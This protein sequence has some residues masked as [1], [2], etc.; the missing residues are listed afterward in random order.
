MAKIQ[1]MRPLAFE[2][3]PLDF[4]EKSRILSKI[5]ENSH[6]PTEDDDC[7]TLLSVVQLWILSSLFGTKVILILTKPINL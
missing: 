4:L 3:I 7:A 1:K 5:V 2:L 6:F